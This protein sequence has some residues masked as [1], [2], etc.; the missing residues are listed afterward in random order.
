MHKLTHKHPYINAIYIAILKYLALYTKLIYT[1]HKKVNL[2]D[3]KYN[4]YGYH[5]IMPCCS[6]KKC[7]LA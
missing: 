3:K 6:I 4:W 1:L 5:F 7:N 2:P